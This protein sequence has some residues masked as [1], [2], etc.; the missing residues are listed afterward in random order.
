[1]GHTPRFN[2]TLLVLFAL[3]LI[4]LPA[5]ARVSAAGNLALNQP[6]TADSSCN[7][8]EGPAKAVNGSVSGGTTDKWCSLGAAKWL[9]VD[10]GAVYAITSIVVRHAGAGG[11]SASWNTRDFSLQAS[12]DGAAWT[13]V[14]TVAGNTASVTT[15]AI[16]ATNA[17]YVRLTI[18]APTQTSDGAARIYELEVYSGGAP[19][20]RLSDYVN[21]LRGSN[22][23]SGYSRG[24]TFPAATRPFGFNFWTPMTDDS[25]DRWIYNYT[26]T[27]LYAFGV[28]HEPSPWMADHGQVQV[29]PMTGSMQ[30]GRDARRSTFSHANEIS[31]AH[32]YSVLLDKYNIRAEIAPTDHAS[33]WRFTFP[34]AQNAF[35]LFDTKD[36]IGGAVTVN[37]A[38]RTISG[39]VDHNGP[40]LYYYAEVNKPIAAFGYPAG[41]GVCSWIQFATAANE[42]VTMKMGTSFISVAQA[43]SNVAQEVG[44]KTFDQVREEGAAEWDAALG[45]ITIDAT[46]DQKTIFYS[47][48]YRAF[49]YPNSMW[50]NVGGT[51]Q[52]FSPYSNTVKNGK[53]YVNNGFWDTF[54]ATWPLYTLLMPTQTGV[55]LDGWVNAYKDGG[56]TPRWSAPGY[57]D[58]MVGSHADIIFADAY[59]K[60]VHNFDVNAAYDSMLKNAMVYSSNGARGRKGNQVSIFKGYI[61]TDVLAESAAWYL[62]DKVNDFGL[63]LLAQAL[64]KATDAQYFL[65]RSLTYANLFSPSV[66][67]FR[68]KQSSGA[69]RTTDANFKPNEWGY[70][71]TEGAPWHYATAAS[72]DPQGMANLYGGRAQLSAK[73]DAVFAAPRDYLVGSYGGVIHEMLEAYDTNMGQYAHANEPIH[74]MIYMYNYAG[75]PW[76]TQARVR[77]VLVNLYSSGLGTGNGYLGDEDNGQMSAWYVFSAL[78]FYPASPG[79][80]EYAIGAPLYTRATINLENGRTFTI[81]APANSAA[82]KYIQSAT[83]NGAALSKNYL[84]HD[85][86]L[87]GGTLDFVMG[88]APSAWGGGASDVPTSITSGSAIPQPRAD[89]ANGG[90]ISASSTNSPAAEQKEQAFDNTSLTKWLIFANAGWLQYQF[91]GGAQQTVRMYTLTSANDVPGRDPRNW[92]LLG[93]NDGAT[94]TTLDTRTGETF[95]WRQQTRVFAVATPAAYAYYRLNISANNGAAE[96]QLAEIELIN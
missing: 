14:A 80:P 28:S 57:S 79:H 83:L 40:R 89:V 5:A 94:W 51:A 92:S 35:I 12:P 1:M 93:S 7:A 4:I 68:G 52:Y 32:Y 25:E 61:P 27:S 45:K 44:A 23:T 2:L 59:V 17:R 77:D 26:N 74:H 84:T 39:Y 81:N 56:W 38:A 24:N 36:G 55:M 6:A 86:I 76:K 31:R 16:A 65:N 41:S 33:I 49:M 69:W 30:S 72:Q 8:N 3:S 71:F 18:T 19:A 95:P 43:Q 20:T 64:G 50:E 70:E 96:T 9:Q 66:G 21:P 54:R 85:Q 63:A 58:I 48:L 88:S 46:E 11:E 90:A 75:T 22:S 67:F 34:S 60:G 82:N 62:E 42:Q 73:I 47:N 87:A 37:Q 91:S 53:I 29:M 10:L 13:T 15:H 78:G